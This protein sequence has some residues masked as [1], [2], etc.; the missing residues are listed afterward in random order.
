M[1][2]AVWD[3]G[4]GWQSQVCKSENE[5]KIGWVKRFGMK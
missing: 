3:E 2:E 5:K 1:A 4:C